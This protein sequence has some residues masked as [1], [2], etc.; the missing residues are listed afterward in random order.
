MKTK[1]TRKIVSKNPEVKGWVE[2]KDDRMGL[3]YLE[4]K[5]VIVAFLEKENNRGWTFISYAFG[6]S[7]V[8]FFYSRGEYEETE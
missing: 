3:F 8:T 5:C 4:D 2:I 6:S 1:K 7:P